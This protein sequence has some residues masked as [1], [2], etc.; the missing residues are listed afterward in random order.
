MS[1]EQDLVRG[2]VQGDD[3]AWKVLCDLHGKRL[4]TYLQRLISGTPVRE[5]DPE[6]LCQE[7]FLKLS[8]YRETIDLGNPIWPYLKEIAWH[9]FCDWIEKQKRMP[10]LSS[11]GLESEIA[12]PS[13]N[14]PKEV[15]RKEE[16]GAALRR[17]IDR[18]S[19][20]H[21]KVV[22]RHYL[23]GEQLVE[24]AESLGL[25][26]NQVKHYSSDGKKKL[27]ECLEESR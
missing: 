23:N 15:D 14:H 16:L 24:I 1:E 3:G 17:C 5:W 9:V 8:R 20:K 7:T 11:L 19:E 2:L 22:Y 13:E 25:T 21:H 18:L 12:D 10:R 27:K 6:D 4:K 26:I